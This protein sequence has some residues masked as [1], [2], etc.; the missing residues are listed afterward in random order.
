MTEERQGLKVDETDLPVCRTYIDAIIGKGASVVR[1]FVF[2]F[3]VS[4]SSEKFVIFSGQVRLFAASA[5]KSRN[6]GIL[7]FVFVRL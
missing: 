5:P 7:V 3:M 1:A 2:L 6:D 4:S